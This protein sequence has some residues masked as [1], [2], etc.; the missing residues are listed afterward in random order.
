MGGSAWVLPRKRARVPGKSVGL[1]A[2]QGGRDALCAPGD[3]WGNVLTSKC[4]S[5]S[6]YNFL[7]GFMG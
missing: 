5:M 6:Q 2:I 3:W 7:P 4:M 1:D